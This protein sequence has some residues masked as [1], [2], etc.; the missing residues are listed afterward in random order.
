MS[1]L[2]S[3]SISPIRIHM[4][5]KPTQCI[6]SQIK[7]PFI[8]QT[9]F[10]FKAFFISHRYLTQISRKF[11]CKGPEELMVNH[12]DDMTFIWRDD[13]IKWKHFPRYWPFVG[14]IHRWP[15]DSL[16]QATDAEHRCFLDLRLNKPLS[17]QSET[18]V[19]RA[20]YDVIVMVNAYVKM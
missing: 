1:V 18:P 8:S 20:R 19:I 15:V 13:V 10:F 17:K 4:Y 16:T 9:T 12:F 5:M 6:E 14:G 2:G 7:W 3:K 11:V